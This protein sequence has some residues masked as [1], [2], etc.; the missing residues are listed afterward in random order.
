M[1]KLKP[2][3]FNISMGNIELAQQ[4]WEAYEKAAKK[5]DAHSLSSWAREILDREA[6]F[7][8]K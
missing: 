8:L 4:R 1:E 7:K 3:G 2:V 6:G 5:V